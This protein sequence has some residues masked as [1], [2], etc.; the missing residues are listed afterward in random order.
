MTPVED[1]N[2]KLTAKFSFPSSFAGFK[3]HFPDNPILPGICMVQAIL[4]M[5]KSHE[6]KTICMKQIV[7]AKFFTTVSC[8]E[9]CVFELSEH[10]ADNGNMLVKTR[11]SRGEKK[12]ARIDLLVSETNGDTE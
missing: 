12:I 3:G 2:E 9:E 6:R 8:D 10:A 1:D 5:L 7:Q 11:I 4:V